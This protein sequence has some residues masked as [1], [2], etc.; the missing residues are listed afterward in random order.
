MSQTPSALTIAGLDPSG[1]AGLTADIKTL[2]QHQ[3]YGMAVATLISVQNTQTLKRVELLAPHL[4]AEQIDAVL[5]DIPPDAVKIGALGSAAIV[6]IVAM[7]TSHLHCPLV[8]DPVM[9][10]KHGYV[11]LP[12]DA[13]QVLISR[14]LPV[15]TLLTPNTHEAAAL[16]GGHPV[17][18][19]A[20][21]RDAARRIGD[22]GPKAVLVKGGHLKGDATDVLLY[23]GQLYEFSAPRIPSTHTHGTGCAYSAAI[24]A[25]L[26]LGYQLPE[27]VERAKTWLTTAIQTPPHVGRGT[28]P[29]NLVTPI[30]F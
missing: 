16:L 11:L 14:L 25:W 20:Q 24:T 28:G 4:V 23:G 22:M 26:A 30:S 7:R 17:T 19:L 13:V 29:I 12:S 5:G 27:A 15:L 8:V 9:V 21:A 3:V 18:T 2:H 1:G 10:S 6:E